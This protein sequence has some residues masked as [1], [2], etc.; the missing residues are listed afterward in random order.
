MARLLKAVRIDS[1]KKILREIH[2]IEGG[3]DLNISGRGQGIKIVSCGNRGQVVR[4][5]LIISHLV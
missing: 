5:L 1:T 2:L 3:I 4:E